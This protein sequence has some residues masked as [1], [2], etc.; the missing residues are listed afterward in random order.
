MLVFLNTKIQ[1]KKTKMS[2]SS[3]FLNKSFF[4]SSQ[5]ISLCLALLFLNA[6]SNQNSSSSGK[7]DAGADGE[8]FAY[9]FAPYWA[10]APF[11]EMLT[12]SPLTRYTRV[13]AKGEFTWEDSR[14]RPTTSA[15]TVVFAISGKPREEMAAVMN[16]LSDS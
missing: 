5:L 10:D 9:F 7:K 12:K 2:Y 16:N 14:G 11:Y 13:F 15:P 1:E 3:V 8:Y 4:T 6:C